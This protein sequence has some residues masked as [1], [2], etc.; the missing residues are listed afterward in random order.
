[1]SIT[2]SPALATADSAAATNDRLLGNRRS[3]EVC[4]KNTRR[5]D[6][7]ARAITR[8]IPVITRWGQNAKVELSGRLRR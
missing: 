4:D 5:G 2:A 6:G 8:S 1:M 7:T 3:S